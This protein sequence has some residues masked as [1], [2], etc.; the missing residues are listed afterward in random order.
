MIYIFLCFT[1]FNSCTHKINPKIQHYYVHECTNLDSLK[2]FIVQNHEKLP[3]SIPSAIANN[4]K[5]HQ[6]PQRADSF[7]LWAHQ[8]FEKESEEPK[9]LFTHLE[10][11][12]KSINNPAELQSHIQKIEN[13]PYFKTFTDTLLTLNFY[14]LLG[15]HHYLQ[16]QYNL[17]AA[18]FRTAYQWALKFNMPQEIERFANNCGALYY[19]LKQNETAINY[20]LIAHD[21]LVQRKG[22]NPVLNN[23]IAAIL[24]FQNKYSEAEN[25]FLS[26]REE[27]QSKN[28]SYQS[29]LI[30]LN[31][32]QLLI[33]MQRYYQAGKIMNEMKIDSIPN[34]F[35]DEYLVNQLNLIQATQPSNLQQFISSNKTHLYKFRF[36]ILGQRN[37]NWVKSIYHSPDLIQALDFKLKDL[38]SLGMGIQ[39]ENNASKF[40]Q[41]LAKQAMASG[42]N[43]Q[44]QTYLEKSY[45]HNNNFNRI[46]DS[47]N[48]IDFQEK[49]KHQ[50]F[51][52]EFEK[53]KIVNDRQ[54]KT[55]IYQ[56]ILFAVL[57]LFSIALITIYIFRNK[58]HKEQNHVMKMELELKVKEAEKLKL[59]NK[60]QSKI[61]AISSLIIERTNE[62]SERLSQPK[63]KKDPEIIDIR[64]DLSALTHIDF[65]N[66]FEL[67]LIKEKWNKPKVINLELFQELS[68][69]QKDILIL[70]VEG[71][72]AKEI[73]NMLNLSYSHVR[74]TRSQLLKMINE[75]GISDFTDLKSES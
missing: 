20:F 41:I 16:Q 65:Q 75:K 48:V 1:V 59:E 36:K 67:N 63:F 6:L 61:N 8:Y 35:L 70:S 13:H 5:K 33:S 25:Y 49:I 26:C 29:Y 62:I 45:F 58:L 57:F 10:L 32:S 31:Y 54:S 27:L 7:I 51:L 37:M 14:N 17:S 43:A 53:I 56:N 66:D 24:I 69:S 22:V 9:L 50:K 72:K 3:N 30:K 34:M 47:L 55:I 15:Q 73:S 11:G 42:N 4:L 60:L 39:F 74:N 23:N 68:K 18:D 2:E 40:Y 44:V 12:F 19:E 52:R 21:Y 38:D 71:I 64:K 28:T 46:S